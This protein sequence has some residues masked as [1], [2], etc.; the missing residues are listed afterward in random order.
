MN[1]RTQRCLPAGM[2]E[3]MS[4]DLV[5]N[6]LTR[7]D[8][9]GRTTTYSYDVRNRQLTVGAALLAFP[10]EPGITRTY[11]ATGKVASIVDASGTTTW[12]YDNQDR[13][14]A[15]ATPQGTLSYTYHPNSLV[16]SVNSS[17]ANGTSVNYVYD[18]INRLTGVTDNRLGNTTTN[19]YDDSNNLAAITYPNGIVH[20][21]TVDQKDHVVGLQVQRNAA[22]LA[23]YGYTR[24]ATGAI[25]SAA[26][27]TG[28]GVNYTYDNAWRLTSETI[29][30]DPVAANN[31]GLTY[32]LDAVANRTSLTSTLAALTNQTFSFDANDR[33]A[34]DTSD[35]NGNTLTSNST[36][37]TYDFLDRLSTA[38]GGIALVYDGDGNRVGRNTTHYLIDDQTP[39]GYTQV[40]EELVGGTVTRRY[41][42]GLKRISQTQ[43]GN[44]TYYLYDGSGSVRAFADDTGSVTDTFTYDVFGN[45]TART[46]ITVSDTLYRGEHFDTG[47]GL[48]YLRSRWYGPQAGRFLTADK[49]EGERVLCCQW[50]RLSL[51]GATGI[52]AFTV[53]EQPGVHH[54]YTYAD[55][56]PVNMT[57]PTGRA[58]ERA[59]STQF[60]V[61]F[62][63]NAGI[64][65]HGAR[66]ILG[67]ISR[68]ET[69][70]IIEAAV[71][72]FLAEQE[73][74]ILV[75]TAWG[76][77]QAMVQG[78]PY[79]YRLFILNATVVNVGTYFP[80][81]ANYVPRRY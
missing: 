4:Y 42:Y 51:V 7:T 26:E 61:T 1:R 37:Y 22:V 21:Y 77:L 49:Y 50:T 17:N 33:I 10:G 75:N 38:T 68:E 66:H 80:R 81:L 54:G 62:S 44:T 34:A 69:E 9:N 29:A 12:T 78:V 58:A 45:V 5:G 23:N 3:I 8:F 15:K 72:E 64:G 48:Y 57:D 14:L 53:H 16:A 25:Q 65:G 41:A 11:T 39:L 76:N 56:D 67:T 52:G 46:G 74:A 55:G 24:A 31:G 27:N 13:F 18:P 35:A 2:C 28:R 70:A 59:L 71:R 73:G 36:I 19:V 6:M 20:S 63:E 60:T 47:L 30:G 79:I 43:V 32:F 40:A